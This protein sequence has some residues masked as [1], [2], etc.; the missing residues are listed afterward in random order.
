MPNKYANSDAL[1]VACGYADMAAAKAY[2][3][4]NPVAHIQRTLLTTLR[5]GYGMT[6]AIS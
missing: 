6:T 3:I 5:T 4:A 2:A 1:A